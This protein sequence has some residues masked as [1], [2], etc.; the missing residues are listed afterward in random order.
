MA[1]NQQAI[2]QSIGMILSTIPG[3]RVMRREFGCDLHRLVFAPNDET[4]AG[5]AIHYITNALSRWEKRIEITQVDAFPCKDNSA[6][7]EIMIAYRIKIL[8]V[9]DQINFLFNLSGEN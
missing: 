5:L 1:E 8:D 7:L 6:V 2:R 9:D 4:T 3:E